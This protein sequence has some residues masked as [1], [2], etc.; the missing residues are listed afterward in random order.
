M[1][2]THQVPLIAVSDAETGDDTIPFAING[3]LGVDKIQRK[4]QHLNP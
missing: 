3:L 4:Y 1:G 2:L